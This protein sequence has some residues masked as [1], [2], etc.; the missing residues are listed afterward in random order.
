MLRL[1]QVFIAGTI[2]CAPFT[3]QAQNIFNSPYSVYGIGMINNRTSSMN[4]SMGGV[5]IGIQDDFNLNPV[6]P[7]SYGAISSPITHVYEIGLYVESNRYRSVQN[8]DSKSTGGINNINYWFKFSKWWAASAGLAPFSSVG[9]KITTPRALGASSDVNYTYSGSGNLNQLYMGNAFNIVKNL[10]LGVNIA[11]IFGSTTKSENIDLATQS[12]TYQN[13]IVARKVNVD[14][15]AQYRFNFKKRALVV[16]VVY[17]DGVTFHG[18]QR[19]SLYDANADT[20]TSSAGKKLTYKIPMSAGIGLGLHSRL[21]VIAADLKYT[22]WTS[23]SFSDQNGLVFQD[24]WKLSA[25]YLYKG[26]PNAENYFGLASL[27]AGFYVQQYQLK[28]DGTS[29][30]SWGLSAG[31]S[32]PVFDGK[33][34]VNLTYSYDRLGTTSNSLILQNSQ[35]IMIDVV[36]RDLWGIKRKFD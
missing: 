18:K 33:S 35:K 7:A 31:V 8:T 9:Y 32:L 21:S 28:L 20:L 23:A 24:T 34:A 12:L 16:G 27:R 17:D 10:S 36:I 13:Q 14:F 11:Y 26:N 29:F 6:N 30:P 19:G 3:L 5:G 22:K 15:G 1:T 2:L 25:G 4:R